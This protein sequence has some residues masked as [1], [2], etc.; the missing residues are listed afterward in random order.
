MK[1]GKN[2]SVDIYNEY[3]K[4]CLQ[5]SHLVVYKIYMIDY[6]DQFSVCNAKEACR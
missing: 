4:M 2:R 3:V 1:Y 6:T 5:W